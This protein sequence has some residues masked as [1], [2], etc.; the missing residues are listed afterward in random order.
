[1]KTLGK[2]L[3]LLGVIVIAVGAYKTHTLPGDL[4][5]KTK[6]FA[7]C[8][9]RPS[10]VSS[11]AT[12]DGHRVAALAYTGDSATAGSM[13]REVVERMG[14]KIEHESPGYLHAVFTTPK[15]RYRDDLE[16]LVLPEGKIDVRSI[17]RFGYRDFGVNRDRVEQ[18]RRAFEAVPQ[19]SG[20]TPTG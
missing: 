4:Y 5:A 11:V 3:L 7:G 8:P 13:L 18:L 2:L 10:C 12:A 17:S 6:T 14:G 1:M 19:P 16:L 20:S 15:M 9:A